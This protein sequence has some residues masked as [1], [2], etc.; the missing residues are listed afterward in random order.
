M[1][2]D[3]KSWQTLDIETVKT[4]SRSIFWVALH[5]ITLTREFHENSNKVPENNV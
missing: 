3:F 1:T 4:Q 5:E 2:R